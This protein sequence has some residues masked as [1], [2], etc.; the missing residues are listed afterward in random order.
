MKK[1][2][3]V[4]YTLIPIK[5]ILTALFPF[6][7]NFDIKF[8]GT[9]SL[10]GV[11]TL[12]REQINTVLRLLLIIT[13]LLL[14]LYIIFSLLFGLIKQKIT[15]TAFMAFVALSLIDFLFA[16]FFSHMLVIIVTA[17]SLSI[18]IVVDLPCICY[19]IINHYEV[20]NVHN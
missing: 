4:A 9:V 15:V 11:L 1:M 13:I 17:I 19:G 5:L 2:F 12:G 16:I 10:W 3:C 18:A 7:S 8:F 20:L 6:A 14:W